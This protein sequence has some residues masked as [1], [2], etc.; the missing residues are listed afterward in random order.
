[1][2]RWLKHVYWLGIGRLARILTRVIRAVSRFFFD[3]QHN[4][5]GHTLHST[6]ESRPPLSDFSG[7][8][9]FLEFPRVF[10]RI[11][12]ETLGGPVLEGNIRAGRVARYW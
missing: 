6:P 10:L 9:S 2:V 3:I 4:G 5:R 7:F 12:A 8:K 11:P 1:M